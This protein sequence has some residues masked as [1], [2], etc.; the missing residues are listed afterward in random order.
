M[1]FLGDRTEVDIWFPL[2]VPPGLG[3]SGAQADPVWNSQWVGPPGR[4]EGCLPVWLEVW[5]HVL[6]TP[7]KP[8]SS[9][10][11]PP[12]GSPNNVAGKIS[13]QAVLRDR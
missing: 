9:H 7:L 8:Y 1:G 2:G 6:D 10:A 3:V 12:Q 13:L 11:L 4:G 5:P